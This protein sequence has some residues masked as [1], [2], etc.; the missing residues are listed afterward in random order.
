MKNFLISIKITL[1]FCVILF[2]GYVLVLWGVA[3]VSQ[4]N[5]GRA[6]TLSLN[7]KVVGAA[8][9][10]QQFTKAGYFWPRPSAVDYNGGG[11][12]GSN[13]GVTNEAYLADVSARVDSFLAAHPY[14]SRHEVPS[15]IVTASASGLD[16]HF[17][18]ASAMVQAQRVAEARGTSTEDII[19]IISLN[20]QTPFV[21]VPFINVLKLNIALD[22]K[23]NN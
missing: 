5:A 2:V 7:G 10:G 23:F 20:T 12:G 6:E 4:P 22:Q 9:V 18:I 14:L 19:K 21:G 8:N 16:P 13:K 15:E 3:A 17:S 1:S 11:S